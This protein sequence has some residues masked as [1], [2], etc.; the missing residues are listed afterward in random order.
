MK[1]I[2][3]IATILLVAGSVSAQTY[4]NGDRA[5]FNSYYQPKIG[6]E[7]SAAISNAINSYSPGYSTNSIA[8]F[9][10]GVHFELPVIY[11]L[12]IVPAV[13]YSQKGY[14]ATTQSGNFTQRSQY[15]D[16]PVL[17][18]FHAG[19]VVNFFVGPQLS[20]MLATSN[21]FGAGFSE[22]S[23]KAYT[24]NGNSLLFDG[25]VGV[26]FNINHVVDLH[27]R[28]TVGLQGTNA[29]GNNIMPT[30]RTQA[31]QVGFGFNIN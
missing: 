15:I 4:F 12:S 11:P 20:Y 26:G 6:F 17:A 22:A 31:W 7:V 5:D 27:A 10:A 19:P 30:Y 8:G 13:L 23:R 16:V 3:A 29:N 28:Y 24:Y 21:D 9:S 25:V 14:Y 2:I 1:K 18:K